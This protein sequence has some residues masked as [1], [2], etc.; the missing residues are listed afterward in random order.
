ML[1]FTEILPPA[2]GA[3]V[4]TTISLDSDRRRVSRQRVTLDNGREAA[5][6]LPRGRV[7]KQDELL[8]AADGTLIRV[9][10]AAEEVVCACA[11]D[12]LSFAKA[13]YH[14]GNR[15]TPLQIEEQ[16]LFFAPD[17]V[18][19]DL[20]RKLGLQTGHQH[21]PFQP[22]EGAY[23][24]VHHHE[25]EAAAK[26]PAAGTPV[27]RT[28][29]STAHSCGA[30]VRRSAPGRSFTSGRGRGYRCGQA[31]RE[32]RGSCRRRRVLLRRSAHE[33]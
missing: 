11:P 20:C 2:A 6:L 32:N 31:L 25:P 18:L 21:R 28:A 29:G 16:E 9:V 3:A 23:A 26:A 1:E 17:R 13:C 24:H 33:A 4:L 22:E 12:A 30:S 15:H 10:C 5:L 14:L 19:E 8:R 27:R 7:L